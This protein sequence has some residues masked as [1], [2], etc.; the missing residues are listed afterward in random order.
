MQYLRV[1]SISLLTFTLAGFHLLG[2]S[3]VPAAAPQQTQQMAK[4]QKL[5]HHG[6]VREP[7]RRS[8]A[9]D[10]RPDPTSEGADA[11]ISTV[12]SVLEN[13]PSK[14][15]RAFVVWSA[16]TRRYRAAALARS[17]QVHD[18]R[19]VYFYDPRPWSPARSGRGRFG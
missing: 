1:V 18:R 14:R 15:L 12:K 7:G 3:Q 2:G 5:R 16:V 13:N 19:L 6:G 9:T 11:A 17:N 10:R 4:L 8:G